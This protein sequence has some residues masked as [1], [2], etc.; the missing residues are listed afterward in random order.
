MLP[1]IEARVP[2]SQRAAAG[3]A[4]AM[5][6]PRAATR[7]GPHASEEPARPERKDLKLNHGF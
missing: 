6:K 3:E 7:G 2:G 1:A 5:R 4:A